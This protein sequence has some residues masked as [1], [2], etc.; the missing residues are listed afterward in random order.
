M[1][2]D[3]NETKVVFNDRLYDFLKFLA[4]IVLPAAGALYFGLAQIWGLP[5]AEEVV[6]TVTVVDTFLGVILKI[7][8]T[9]YN[10]SDAKYD[11]NIQVQDSGEKKTFTLQLNGDPDELDQKDSVIFKVDTK[12]GT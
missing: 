5:K 1:Q 8:S 9:R 10:N 3:N 6:G 7:S 2:R 4:L 11:G 12:P